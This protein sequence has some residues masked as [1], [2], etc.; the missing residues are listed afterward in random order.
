MGR[1]SQIL[2]GQSAGQTNTGPGPSSN[3]TPAG[4]PPK[5]KFIPLKPPPDCETY[6][7]DPRPDLA[8]DHE[9]W[10]RV[11]TEAYWY[12]QGD[13]K[14]E[15]LY[16]TLHGIRCGGA[17]VQEMPTGNLKLL[18]GEWKEDEWRQVTAKYLGP[19]KEEVKAI[20][21]LAQATEV[22][23]KDLPAEV[24]EWLGLKPEIEQGKLF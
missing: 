15:Q 1:Y 19:Y 6:W 2:Q 18:P 5:F 4:Q 22:K 13:P 20:L 24:R 12:C 11:L 9:L 16:S 3:N 8:E 14:L 7:H 23:I 21:M 10:I 17:R